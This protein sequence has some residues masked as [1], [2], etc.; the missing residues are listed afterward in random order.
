M[1]KITN[2]YLDINCFIYRWCLQLGVIRRLL[3]LVQVR[4]ESFVVLVQAVDD[5]YV[6]HD[7]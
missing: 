7:G 4:F 3:L 5:E 6:H 1:Y 2:K